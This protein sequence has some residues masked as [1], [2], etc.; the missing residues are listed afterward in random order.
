MITKKQ[1]NDKYFDK[2]I[3]VIEGFDKA[4]LGIDNET[5]KVCYSFTKLIDVC[6]NDGKSFDDAVNFV[7]YDIVQ[8]KSN[9]FIFIDDIF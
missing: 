2:E 7:R 3:N 9:Q 8:E 4:I 1:I 5:N 6:M